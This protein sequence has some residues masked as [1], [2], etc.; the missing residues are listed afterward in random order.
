MNKELEQLKALARTQSEDE[1]FLWIA[2]YIDEDLIPDEFGNAYAVKNPVQYTPTLNAHLDTVHDEDYSFGFVKAKVE[3]KQVFY[4]PEAQV[5]WSPTGIGG[6]DICG[7]FIACY[8]FKHYDVPLQIVFTSGEE[9]GGHGAREFKF[10]HEPAYIV[11]ID[12]RGSKDL[13]T[14]I[15][16]QEL[17]SKGLRKKVTAMAKKHG[18]TKTSGLFSDAHTFAC[19]GYATMNMSCG[20]YNPHQ[21]TEYIS[22]P[23][24]IDTEKFVVDILG[25][26]P[27][28][29]YRAGPAAK[30]EIGISWG[31]W[32]RSDYYN[33]YYGEDYGYGSHNDDTYSGNCEIC[34]N[35]G[36]YVH[37]HQMVLCKECDD[38]F[39][40][41][42]GSYE[43]KDIFEL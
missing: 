19:K 21:E 35:P 11:T 5:M 12:R 40:K 10:T 16:G 6:D 34:S 31:K 13:V 25:N 36:G 38:T 43:Q 23:D 14:S 33:A 9:S 2:E 1:R 8:I 20:Y 32:S 18:R 39:S 22:I 37:R 7:L 29:Q 27:L 28:N 17:M 42:W 26:V 4:D 30:K 15:S 3:D 24:M 41:E